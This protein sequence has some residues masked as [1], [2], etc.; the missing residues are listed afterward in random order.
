MRGG[1]VRGSR[2]TREHSELVSKWLLV[3]CPFVRLWALEQARENQLLLFNQRGLLSHQ[4]GQT[5]DSPRFRRRK[6]S[7]WLSAK[8]EILRPAAA[9]LVPGRKQWFR[10]ASLCTKPSDSS[11]QH[12]CLRHCLQRGARSSEQSRLRGTGLAAAD[13]DSVLVKIER[14]SCGR[15]Q[16]RRTGGRAGDEPVTH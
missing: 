14:V 13:G 10:V 4:R 11:F 6:S 8:G 1:R 7:E 5:L 2:E 15:E 3:W 12:P 16:V 9:S